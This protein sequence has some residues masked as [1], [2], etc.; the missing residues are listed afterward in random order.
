M[1]Q[2]ECGYH[3]QCNYR[4]ESE[5]FGHPFDK[6]FG[7][8]GTKQS[9][10][11]IFRN[12]PDPRYQRVLPGKSESHHIPRH[13]PTCTH[14]QGIFHAQKEQANIYISGLDFITRESFPSSN[15]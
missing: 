11:C 15:V 9:L 2:P 12:A 5:R 6:R 8:A 4:R 13:P 10:L 3:H 7:H 1:S 14:E